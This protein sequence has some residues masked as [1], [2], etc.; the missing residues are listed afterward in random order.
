MKKKST[1][2]YAETAEQTNWNAGMVEYP[3]PATLEQWNIGK[4]GF[5]GISLFPIIPFF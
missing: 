3:K 4:L 1:A 2:E 5:R